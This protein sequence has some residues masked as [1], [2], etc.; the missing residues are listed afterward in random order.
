MEREELLSPRSFRS[1]S[2]FGA[3]V[4]SVHSSLCVLDD[5]GDLKKPQM[6][7]NSLRS[8]CRGQKASIFTQAHKSSV[9]AWTFGKKGPQNSPSFD[10]SRLPIC[11]LA[12][13]S[14]ICE[15]LESFCVT[16][17]EAW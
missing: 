16:S 3:S 15:F 6:E 12:R 4:D 1:L 9:D 11:L 17:L 8:P 13:L 2:S 14:L 5:F 7:R 10:P